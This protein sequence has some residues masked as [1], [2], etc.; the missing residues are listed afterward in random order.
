MAILIPDQ[1]EDA[2]SAILTVFSPSF[3]HQ[4]RNEN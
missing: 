3:M 4:T 1:R 2:F